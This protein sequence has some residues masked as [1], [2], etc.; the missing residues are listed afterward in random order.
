MQL[1]EVCSD[2]SL[3]R[4]FLE[5]DDEEEACRLLLNRYYKTVFN[6]VVKMMRDHPDPAVDADDITSETFIRA[7][8]KRKEIQKP[9]RLLGWLLTAA[10]N[11]TI[12]SIRTSERRTRHLSI[13]S[14]DNL[15]VREEDVP[16]ASIIAET[17]AEQTEVKRYLTMQLFRLLPEQDREIADLRLDGFSPKEIAEAVGSTPGAIQKRWERLIAWLSPVAVHLDALVECLPED[18][19]RKIMERYLDGQPL[20][21]IAKA[22]GISCATIEETVKRV[23]AAW[24]KATKQNPTDP[25]SAMANMRE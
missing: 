1:D 25:V 16:F 7:F 11:L 21:E 10:K 19:D 14:L 6:Y 20:S 4:Q 24:K 15:S 8:N 3:N 22:I 2:V 5:T 23:I 18:D 13:Q 12:D 17:G 9:E